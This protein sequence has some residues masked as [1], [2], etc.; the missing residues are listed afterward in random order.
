MTTEATKSADTSAEFELDWLKKWNL[1]SPKAI[2]IQDGESGRKFS[3]SELY[4][5]S[6]KTAAYLEQTHGITIGDRVAV[7]SGNELEYLVLYFG[8]QRLGAIL[9]PVNFRLTERE[10]LHI[11]NDCGAKLLLYQ[12]EYKEIAVGSQIKI[13]QFTN[14]LDNEVTFAS[15]ILKFETRY[16]DFVG[17][18]NTP[19]MIL[20]TSG[21]TGKPKG[22]VLTQ[23]SIFWNSLNTSISLNLTQNECAV[24]FLPLFHTGGWNVLTTPILHRGG[25]LIFLKKFD[26]DQI[27]KISSRE[28][29]TLLFGVPTTMAMMAVHPEFSHIDLS[30]IRYAIV[31]GEPMLLDLIQ[32]WHHKGIPVRQGYG[33]T[34]FGPN[35]FSLK[36]ED[37]MRKIGSI[38]FPNFYVKVDVRSETSKISE[39]SEDS[40]SSKSLG[41]NEIGELV[42]QGPMQMK[43]YW[44]NPAAT[45]DTIR[46][47]WLYTGDLVRYDEEGYFYIVGR[48][49]DMFISGAENVYP[50]EIEQ[51][52]RQFSGVKEAAVIG[53]KDEKWGEVGKAFVVRVDEKVTIESLQK[54]CLENLAK[55]KIP[56][57]FIFLNELPKGESGKIQKRSL[58]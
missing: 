2:A 36:K 50:A 54:H 17:L 13:Q 10:A 47:G 32:K 6:L 29:A 48:K 55:Y 53:V 12:R 30:S 9:V 4:D 16:Q 39:T 38:G 5:L 25:K 26:A 45:K 1:Y 22:A 58:N 57:Y 33:L 19:T 35:V 52:L 40:D 23:E 34:E 37:C 11:I 46:N 49:K 7:L 28:K 15:E 56:K 3:Y 51:V 41:P 20:Y 14:S 8:L 24:I 21:T 44:N 42:L 31:G 43:E 27:L 18:K